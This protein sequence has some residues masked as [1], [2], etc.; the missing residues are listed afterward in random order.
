MVVSS[1][2][3]IPSIASSA[4]FFEAIHLVIGYAY[5]FLN[6]EKRAAMWVKI[7]L[8]RLNYKLTYFEIHN[9]PSL[10]SFSNMTAFRLHIARVITFIVAFQI[11]NFGLFAQDFQPLAD[12]SISPELNIINSLYEYV[13]EVVLDHKDAVPENNKH[14]QKD[15][16]AHKH[17]QYKLITISKPQTLSD[18][19]L[20]YNNKP[21]SLV[22]GYNYLFCKDIYPPPPKF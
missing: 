20:V 8:I 22:K 21:T 18:T 6:S 10:H 7:N 9:A 15:L 1:I 13:A 12:S 16:Q 4:S 11:M 2:N 14:P 19:Q 17:I 5:F 3:A